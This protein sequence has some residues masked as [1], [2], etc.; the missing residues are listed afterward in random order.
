[1][2]RPLSEPAERAQALD[3]LS[4]QPHAKPVLQF[5]SFS[6]PSGIVGSVINKIYW[7]QQRQ[8]DSQLP[9]MFAGLDAI[10]C[11]RNRDFTDLYHIF[12]MLKFILMNWKIAAY[13]IS[14]LSNR[15]FGALA[16]SLLQTY[17]FSAN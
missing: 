17:L 8:Q 16:T 9:A 3:V 4:S 15:G 7:I 6:N 14:R 12:V 1:L 10:K 11:A 5:A 2:T 13:L